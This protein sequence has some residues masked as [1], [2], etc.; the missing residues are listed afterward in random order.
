MTVTN[1]P[2]PNLV[3]VLIFTLHTILNGFTSTVIGCYCLQS[4][5]LQVNG[6]PAG[7]SLA[8]ITSLLLNLL[9]V[10]VV[11]ATAQGREQY[12][13]FKLSFPNF[14]FGKKKNCCL[15]MN[16]AVSLENGWAL[17]DVWWWS[18][19]LRLF[20]STNHSKHFMLHITG[21]ERWTADLLISRAPALSPEPTWTQR[22]HFFR[23]LTFKLWDR[24]IRFYSSCPP[25][26]MLLSLS[27]LFPVNFCDVLVGPLRNVKHHNHKAQ[28]L[29]P[30]EWLGIKK[31]S[32]YWGY[33]C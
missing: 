24:K 6:K 20:K 1:V 21:A 17:R 15:W 23:K 11:M 19:D 32:Y 33:S 14:G 13:I 5:I 22:S 10:V 25:F 29:F 26:K 18:N 31:N 27:K 3:V 28:D 2:M 12:N 4:V 7:W 8:T 16:C 9:V 30:A